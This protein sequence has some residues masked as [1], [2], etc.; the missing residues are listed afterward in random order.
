MS[1]AALSCFCKISTLPRIETDDPDNDCETL[2]LMHGGWCGP[3][4]DG[5]VSTSCARSVKTVLEMRPAVLHADEIINKKDQTQVRYLLT[6]LLR[7]KV[8]VQV[9]FLQGAVPGLVDQP[10]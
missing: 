8:P 3:V 4:R 7:Q 2:S 6:E 10:G 9:A 1:E 5:G